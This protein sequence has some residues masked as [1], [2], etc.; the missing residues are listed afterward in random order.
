MA[1]CKD[2]GDPDVPECLGEADERYT[3]RFDDI[4]EPPLH[5]CAFCGPRTQVL[6]EAL[7]NAFATR[8]GFAGELEA[9]IDAVKERAH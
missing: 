6:N 2:F 1:T 9:A 8:V 4:G 5:W 3:M 7:Q